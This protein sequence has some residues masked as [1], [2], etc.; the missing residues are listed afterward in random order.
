MRCDPGAIPWNSCRCDCSIGNENFVKNAP[1]D[2]VAGQKKQ[3]DQLK[4][5]V[6]SLRESLLRL[7][8]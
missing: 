7:K 2:V 6:D 5:K 4:S 8:S 3:L 1:E